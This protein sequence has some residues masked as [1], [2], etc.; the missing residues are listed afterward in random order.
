MSYPTGLDSGIVSIA[1]IL[2]HYTN[3]TG[4]STGSHLPATCPATA[5]GFRARDG[6]NAAV[7]GSMAR[8]LRAQVDRELLD[9]IG[10]RSLREADIQNGLYRA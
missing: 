10:K 4:G 8:N 1:S 3:L 5:C 2:S 9:I 6:L 7:S